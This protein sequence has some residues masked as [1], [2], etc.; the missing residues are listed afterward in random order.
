MSHSIQNF[1]EL[2]WRRFFTL[3]LPALFEEKSFSHGGVD[4]RLSPSNTGDF[5]KRKDVHGVTEVM[6]LLRYNID[7]TLSDPNVINS[8]ITLRE[9]PFAKFPVFTQDGF[10]MNGTHWTIISECVPA[11]GWYYGY[12]KNYPALTLNRNAFCVMKI[13]MNAKGEILLMPN[14]NRN[15]TTKNKAT[16]TLFEFL[17]ALSPSLS[18]E[19]LYTILSAAPLATELYVNAEELPI[20]VCARKVAKAFG[21]TSIEKSANPVEMLQTY[22]YDNRMYIGPERM[23]RFMNS[24]SFNRAVGC[25]LDQEVEV[26]GRIIGAGTVLTSSIIKD[27]EDAGIMQLNVRFKGQHRHLYKIIPQENITFEEVCAVVYNYLLFCDGLGVEDDR[28]SYCNKVLSSVSADFQDQISRQLE[29]ICGIIRRNIDAASGR[30]GIN[31]LEGVLNAQLVNRNINNTTFWDLLK[32]SGTTQQLEE[33]NSVAGFGQSFQLTRTASNLPARSRD[34]QLSQKGRVCPYTTSESDRV[35]INTSLS[36]LATIDKYGFLCTPYRKVVNGVATDE[37]VNINPIEERGKLIATLELD[38][39]PEAG[40]GLE[41]V[42]NKVRLNGEMVTARY[43]DIDYQEVSSMALIG[44]L[45]SMIPSA[46]RDAGK[47]LIMSVKAQQQAIPVVNRERAFV[48]TGAEALMDIGVVRARDILKSVL[49]DADIDTEPPETAHLVLIGIEN[50]GA[51]NVLKF[52]TDWNVLPGVYTYTLNCMNSTMKG[53]PKHQRVRE[54]EPDASGN[55]VYGMNDIVVHNYDVDDNPV[56][57]SSDTVSFGNISASTDSIADHAVALGNNVKVLFK[58]WEGSGYEDSIIVN[59]DFVTRYGLAIITAKRIKYVLSEGESFEYTNLSRDRVPYMD[60]NGLPKLGTLL[61]AGQDV[62]IRRAKGENGASRYPSVKLN[63][64][65]KG[66]VISA[67]ISYDRKTAT[68]VLGDVLHLEEGDKLAGTHGNKGVVGRIVPYHEMPFM[69]NGEVPDIILNPL[70]VLSRSNLGQMTEHMI[71]FIGMKTGEVQV[72]PPFSGV[73]ISEIVKRSEELGLTE[74]DVYDGR[75]GKKFDKKGTLGVMHFLRLEHI[76]T[77]KYN[78]CSDGAEVVNQRTMQVNRDSGGGQRISE[79]TSW[80][81]N[82]YGATAL[83]DSLMTIQSDDVVGKLNLRDCI[84]NGIPTGTVK[85][86]SNNFGLLNAYYRILGLNIVKDKDGVR[87]EHLTSEDIRQLSNG[88]CDLTR[89]DAGN[90]QTQYSMLRDPAIFGEWSKGEEDL[91]KSREYYGRLPLKCEIVMPIFLSQANWCHMFVARTVRAGKKP[92]D[93]VHTSTRSLSDK[94]VS[95]VI[96]GN[97]YL[98]E[99]ADAG[100]PQDIQ[101]RYAAIYGF[102]TGQYF[103]PVFTDDLEIAGISAAAPQHSGITAIVEMT[104][105]YN[106]ASTLAFMELHIKETLAKC[107]LDGAYPSVMT[108][109]DDPDNATAEDQKVYSEAIDA[110]VKCL[111]EG[112]IDGAKV[113]DIRELITRRNLVREVALKDRLDSFVVDAIAVPPVGYRPTYKDA[114]TTAMDMQ[115][116]TVIA[117]VKRLMVEVPNTSGWYYAQRNVYAAVASMIQGKTTKTVK[118]S[119][120]VLEELSDHSTR[121]AVMRDTLLAKRITHSGRSVISVNSKLKLGE[122]GVPISIASKILEDFIVLEL[123]TNISDYPEFASL[124]IS[125]S[126]TDTGS[127]RKYKKL[128]VY[129]SNNNINGFADACYLEHDAYQKF[130]KCKLELIE[131]LKKLFDKWAVLLGREPSL[132]KFSLEAFKG[133]PVDTYSIQLHPLACHGFNADFDGD[134]MMIAIPV[135][136]AGNKDAKEKMMIQDNLINPKDCELICSINQD[137]ILGLYYA[138]IYKGNATT[139][140]MSNVVAYYKQQPLEDGQFDGMCP[141]YLRELYSDLELGLIKFHDTIAVECNQHLYVSTAGR[142]LLNAMYSD[143]KGF[144]DFVQFPHH[145]VVD[146]ADREL[147]QKYIQLK[148]E[149]QLNFSPAEI[150]EEYQHIIDKYAL[151]Y[152]GTPVYALRT[153][154]VMSKDTVKKLTKTAIAYYFDHLHDS[155]DSFGDTLG[156][157]LDRIKEY[158]FWAADYSGITLSLFDFDRLPIPGVVSHEMPAIQ[159]KNAEIQEAY[160]DGIITEAERKKLTIASWQGFK[161]NLSKNVDAALR[162]QESSMGIK[163]DPMDNIFMMVA[164]GARG[165]T[166]QLMEISGIIGN[167]TNASGEMLESPI[168]SNYMNGLTTTESFDNSYTARRQVMAAQLSTAKAGQTT[169]ELIYDNEHLHIRDSDETCDA[170]SGCIHLEYTAQALIHTGTPLV[171]SKEDIDSLPESFWESVDQFDFKNL[172]I[173]FANAASKVLISPTYS[174]EMKPLLEMLRPKYIVVKDIKGDGWEPKLKLIKYTLTNKSRY[175]LMYRCIDLSKVPSFQRD[176]FVK[177]SALVLEDKSIEDP[178]LRAASVHPEWPVIGDKMIDYI[179]YCGMSEV[180]IYTILGCK[181]TKGICKR[182]FG[183]KYDTRSFPMNNEYIGYQAVQSIGEPIAQLVLDSHKKTE[184]DDGSTSLSQLQGL[185][186]KPLDRE[187]SAILAPVHGVVEIERNPD[188]PMAATLWINRHTEREHHWNCTT[189]NLKVADGMYVDAGMPMTRGGVAYDE[190]SKYTDFLNVQIQFWTDFL[191]V[192]GDEKIMARNFECLARSQ[193]E[194]GCAKTSKGDI[195]AG[196][197]YHVNKLRENGVPFNPAI[198]PYERAMRVAGKMFTTLAL[199]DFKRGAV[200]HIMHHTTES[201]DSNIGRSLIGDLATAPLPE[202]MGV[203]S[204]TTRHDFSSDLLTKFAETA[205]ASGEVET[206]TEGEELDLSK[207]IMGVQES[208]DVEGSSKVEVVAPTEEFKPEETATNP[209]SE[210]R[211]SLF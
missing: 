41:D 102:P 45:I 176:E 205:R 203:I 170:H 35:G 50:S 88:D 94:L 116:R 181:S 79:L 161:K 195:M 119:S 48:T 83:L 63:P 184:A 47:R 9:L 202:T 144:T 78:A 68:V 81:I 89:G 36:A 13:A 148:D 40:H 134:Q 29:E 103:Y 71:S 95:E 91:I 17:K 126:D 98:F 49:A 117:A 113:Q 142:I 106:I 69:E 201:K 208:A 70:G 133:V 74:M 122:V 99:W 15:S 198:L 30:D 191:N 155:P 159:A 42:T 163:F 55:H 52:S 166:G 204:Q 146:E 28:D 128:L 11:S 149:H 100:I 194:F 211:T 5:I 120:T 84:R 196:S 108:V 33:T 156:M 54:V 92:T 93:D 6:E 39:S 207:F 57:L 114:P 3:E 147:V 56:K 60:C 104:K 27:I 1:Q 4:V 73:Q 59:Q 90:S 32:K 129:L 21:L 86:G 61:K 16:V 171:L 105:Q 12:E 121:H 174:N 97:Y 51:T 164:S 137:M 66:Y 200:Y 80:C 23:P 132:H 138:T 62:I 20:D 118:G 135:H 160:D 37:T 151:K 199:S 193:S 173:E 131:I 43:A 22:F 2:A 125:R 76:A 165:S 167:V 64:G 82:S 152:R 8:R 179:E 175:M 112:G 150:G 162:Q 67:Q 123:R 172:W 209:E 197:V 7:L 34:V 210:E 140:D 46:E 101:D 183:I 139:F 111:A 143:L 153:D 25:V 136:E 185:M 189:N 10:V 19:D 107:G 24:Q 53:S 169:R 180:Y 109:L 44:P 186:S 18:F 38:L 31:D 177:R 127:A 157:F 87:L 65:E 26:N 85:Y 130:A 178:R 14:S 75:T 206:S 145:T 115:L 168:L 158:G 192:F 182:C 187:T 188:E 96:R 110:A 72:L 154:V 141:Q 124:G 190:M 58:S 77:S